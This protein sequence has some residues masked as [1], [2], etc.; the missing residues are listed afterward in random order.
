VSFKHTRSM[1]AGYREHHTREIRERVNPRFELRREHEK[2]EQERQP[3]SVNPNPKNS[4]P[5]WPE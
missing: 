1:P 5:V 3:A 4:R 2:R